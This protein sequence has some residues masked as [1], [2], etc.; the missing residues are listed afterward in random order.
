MRKRS[1]AIKKPWHSLSRAQYCEPGNRRPVSR[2]HASRP[3]TALSILAIAA[4]AYLIAVG[5]TMLLNWDTFSFRAGAL[6]LASFETAGPFAF[7]I[8]AAV[9]ALIAYGLWTLRNW[10]RH[11]AMGIAALQAVLALPKVSENAIALNFPRLVVTGLPMMAAAALI[12]YLA[13]PSTS[14]AFNKR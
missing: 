10:A 7:L 2:P 1:S 3:I 4:S 9:Y 13:K 11:A 12:F 8:G 14:A 6:L 5:T